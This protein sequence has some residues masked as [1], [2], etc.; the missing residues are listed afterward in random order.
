MANYHYYAKV[1]LKGHL[2]SCCSTVE[3]NDIELC[4]C[5]AKIVSRCPKCNHL[6]PALPWTYRST[7]NT[8]SYKIPTKCENCL[9]FF[10]WNKSF[11]TQK[12]KQKHSY[13]I[14]RFSEFLK[15]IFSSVTHNVFSK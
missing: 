14:Y 8:S 15:S 9:E 7:P 3:A 2:V 12:K 4:H 1:C 11:K 10:P 13:F 6:I 5:G